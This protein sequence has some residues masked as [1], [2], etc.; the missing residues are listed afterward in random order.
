[1][2]NDK[3]IAK[4][5]DFDDSRECFSGVDIAGGICYFL[6]DAG[7]S[8]LCEV[9]NRRNGES[10]SSKR[11]LSDFNSFVRDTRATAI[12]S[13]IQHKKEVTLDQIVFSRKPFGISN[14]IGATS[15]FR[16]SIELFGSTG[17]TYIKK[18]DITSNF[19][20]VDKYKVIMSKTSA[21]HAGQSDA[22]GRKK[23]V[24]RIK[25]LSPNVICT[26]SYLL[27][28]V[29]H[30]K[31]Q[32]ENMVKYI[33]TQ[34]VRAMLSTILLTQNISKDK[35]AFVPVQKFDETSDINWDD[36]IEG[37]NRQLYRKYNLTAEDVA[38]IEST[39]KPME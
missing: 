37:I 19:E 5:V 25:V 29:F 10:V 7:H 12:I 11:S 14:N 34:F 9:V 31:S 26:E 36:S 23:V 21:E 13:K 1:M 6:W 35:F 39:I 28:S 30:D 32:A 22:Q 18:E 20:L 27:L 3:R 16:G 17:V 33:K 2:L 24:S 8:D 38:F 15:P 4:L